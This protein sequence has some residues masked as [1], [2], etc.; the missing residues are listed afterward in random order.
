MYPWWSELDNAQVILSRLTSI[1]TCKIN[2]RH[3]YCVHG[4]KGSIEVT[5]QTSSLWS[6][7]FFQIAYWSIK[8]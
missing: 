4:I 3:G 7:C 8:N 6:Q 1:D 2:K 5:N